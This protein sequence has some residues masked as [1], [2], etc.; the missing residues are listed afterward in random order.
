MSD[1]TTNTLSNLNDHL[2]S[3][4]SRLSDAKGDKLKEEIERTRAMSTLAKEMI[5]NA[6]LALEVQRCLGG[7]PDTPSMLQ[8][9]A[10]R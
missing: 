8:V 1:T 5:E 6:K 3:Q 4:L 10:P 2:F 7:K 9:E